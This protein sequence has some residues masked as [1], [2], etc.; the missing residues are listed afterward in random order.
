VQIKNIKSISNQ[1]LSNIEEQKM[2]LIA[3]ATILSHGVLNDVYTILETSKENLKYNLKIGDKFGQKSQQSKIDIVHSLNSTQIEVDDLKRFHDEKIANNSYKEEDIDKGFQIAE[4]TINEIKNTLDVMHTLLLN[5]ISYDGLLEQ[6]LMGYKQSI[7]EYGRQIENL[8]LSVSGG[9]VIGLEGLSESQANIKTNKKAQLES[10][11]TQLQIAEES[12]ALAKQESKRQLD[13]VD[14]QTNIL[15]NQLE[16]VKNGLV[17]AKANY[18]AQVQMMKTQSDQIKGQKDLA[19]VSIENTLIKAPYDGVITE[20]MTEEGIV[21]GAGTPLFKF[22]NNESKKIKIEI[23]ENEAQQIGVGSIVKMTSDTHPG[24]ILTG[25][26]KN[27]ASHA[28]SITK[29]V[30]AEIKIHDEKNELQVGNF[31]R[32]TIEIGA[33]QLKTIIPQKAVIKKEGKSHIY[34]IQEDTASLIPVELGEGYEEEYEVLKGVYKGNK[35]VIKGIDKL[36]SG[37]RIEY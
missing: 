17:I 24:K 11:K 29:K 1:N 6:E 36:R 8:K 9:Q 28:N 21:I 14:S 32:V 35:I 15:K 10:A 18:N 7:V 16:E 5:T 26:I 2:R 20:K 25:H 12:L 34:I 27:I 23:P 31:V 30:P 33:P 22:I 19:M 4:G 13:E 3:Q 37:D